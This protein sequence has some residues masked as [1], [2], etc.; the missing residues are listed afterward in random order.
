MKMIVYI[1]YGLPAPL[2]QLLRD[3]ST[4]IGWGVHLIIQTKKALGLDSLTCFI[5]MVLGGQLP[6]T[7]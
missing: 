4:I 3:N 2:T 6:A 5:K 1:L 7:Q